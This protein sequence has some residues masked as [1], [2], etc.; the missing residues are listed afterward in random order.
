MLTTHVRQW[1]S[2]WESSP[3]NGQRPRHPHNHCKIH[4][5]HNGCLPHPMWPC[6]EHQAITNGIL[7]N[8]NFEQ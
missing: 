1:E 4:R 2:E 6:L 3:S 7:E 5:H 8:W